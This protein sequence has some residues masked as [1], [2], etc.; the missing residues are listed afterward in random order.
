MC[1]PDP[2]GQLVPLDPPA[3]VSGTDKPF[4]GP[5]LLE[6]GDGNILS[7]K[8]SVQV[9]GALAAPAAGWPLTPTPRSRYDGFKMFWQ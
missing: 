5:Q 6:P 8:S 2:S 4:A 1:R 9:A 7:P 3:P